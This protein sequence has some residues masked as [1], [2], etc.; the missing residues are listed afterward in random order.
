VHDLSLLILS[1]VSAAPAP[2]M[3]KGVDEIKLLIETWTR[4]GQALVASV[5]SLAFIF[6]FIWKITAVESH[7]ALAAKQWIQRIVVG[8]IGVEVAV[9]LVGILTDS[10]APAGR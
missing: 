10:V 1:I 8:T 6:A 7:S 5:G 9:S 3:P 4:I 2:P